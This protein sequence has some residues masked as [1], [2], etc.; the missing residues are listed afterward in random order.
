MF[1]FVVHVLQ[2]CIFFKMK[3]NLFIIEFYRDLNYWLNNSYMLIEVFLKC[4]I[5]IPC[6]ATT[7]H[8]LDQKEVVHEVQR[9]NQRPT[10]E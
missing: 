3:Y 2:F 8:S 10:Q 1:P 9:M 7:G 6:K 4:R 5:T